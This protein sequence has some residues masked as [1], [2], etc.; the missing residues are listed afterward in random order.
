ICQD[1]RWQEN[2]EEEKGIIC[3]PIKKRVAAFRSGPF[4]H[5]RKDDYFLRG[6]ICSSSVICSFVSGFS[7]NFNFT[8][9]AIAPSRSANLSVCNASFGWNFAIDSFSTSTG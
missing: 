2:V 3:S 4:F 5:S 8:A 7:R 6:G 9:S 1:G